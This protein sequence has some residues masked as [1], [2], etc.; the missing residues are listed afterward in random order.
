MW[1]RNLVTGDLDT[2]DAPFSCMFSILS[3]EMSQV[4]GESDLSKV[5]HKFPWLTFWI[6]GI[7]FMESN[8]NPHSAVEVTLE[9]S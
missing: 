2:R 3:L 7:S 1:V 5:I 6:T 9:Q 4:P 8:Q